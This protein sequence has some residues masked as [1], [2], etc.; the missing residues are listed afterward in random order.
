MTREDLHREKEQAYMQGY[1]DA[2]KKYRAIP[3]REKGEWITKYEHK[4]CNKCGHTPPSDDDHYYILSNFCPNCGADMRDKSCNTC[5]NNG[6]EFS[7]E[8]YECVKNIQNHYEPQETDFPQAE[9][10]RLTVE[11]FKRTMDNVD[12]LMS[13]EKEEEERIANNE[14]IIWNIIKDK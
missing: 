4:M 3:E 14:K 12:K 13:E 5:K 1:E 2:S 10:I 11:S 7:G 9:D 8:C 6:D